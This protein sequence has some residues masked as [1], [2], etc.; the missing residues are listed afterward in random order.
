MKLECVIKDTDV[1]EDPL[2]HRNY[3]VY[4]LEVTF[5]GEKTWIVKQQYR[6]FI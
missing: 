2:D 5:N 4:M 3:T 6:A 1:E